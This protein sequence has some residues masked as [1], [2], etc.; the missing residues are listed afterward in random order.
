MSTL[1]DKEIIEILGDNH[2]MT[3]AES[4]IRSDAFMKTD[5]E[6]TMRWAEITNQRD[7]KRWIK[8]QV[9]SRIP[10]LLRPFLYFFYRYVI[11][12]GFLDGRPG[13]IYHFSHAFLYQ[14]IISI[15]YID[16]KERRLRP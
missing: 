7:R 9:W 5:A 3:S 2:Q 10:T 14:F 6:K 15:V 4:P 8:E 1:T 16:E 13:F 12:V 11:Q